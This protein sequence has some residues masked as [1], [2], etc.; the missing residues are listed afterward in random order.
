MLTT[1]LIIFYAFLYI[2]HIILGP[3][4][5]TFIVKGKPIKYRAKSLKDLFKHSIYITYISLLFVINFLINPNLEN[6]LN[7]LFLTVL[8][9]IIYIIVYNKHN[10]HFVESIILHF[11][12]ILPFI[13]FLFYYNIR[14][15]PFCP[16]FITYFTISL[17]I[18]YA[19]T[20][21]T[22]YKL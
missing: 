8:S 14:F 9:F 1:I 4:Y 13:F 19:F 12:L 22:I 6:F 3:Y 10:P 11:S 15:Q 16:S 21:K 7:A 17:I 18:I 20:Y 5:Y 2:S